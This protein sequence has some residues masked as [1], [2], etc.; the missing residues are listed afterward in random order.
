[1][2]I[3][4]ISS[5]IASKQDNVSPTN[6]ISHFEQSQQS[7]NTSIINSEIQVSMQSGNEPLSLLYKTALNAINEKLAPSLGEN[8]AQKAFENNLDTSPQATA[9]RIVKGATDLF[10]TFKSDRPELTDDE[11]IDNF[12]NIISEGIETGFNEAKDILDGLSVLNGE[13]EENIASTFALVQT[14]LEAFRQSFSSRDEEGSETTAP[15][16]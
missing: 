2:S 5:T 14:G 1:M 3:T 16:N 10:T 15:V 4:N 8:A 13:I 6:N 7:K 12:L 9:D 11:A